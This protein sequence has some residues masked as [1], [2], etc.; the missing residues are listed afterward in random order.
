MDYMDYESTLPHIS[1]TFFQ[2][3]KFYSRDQVE[4]AIHTIP[5]DLPDPAGYDPQA[6]KPKPVHHNGSKMT[7]S[8][9]ARMNKVSSARTLLLGDTRKAQAISDFV[10]TVFMKD[11]SP[12]MDTT[13]ENCLYE[14]WL[15]QISN[16]DFIY[17]NDTG[18]P[19]TA[20]DLRLQLLYNMSVDYKLYTSKVYMHLEKPYKQWCLEQLDEETPSDLVAISALRHMFQVNVHSFLYLILYLIPGCTAGGCT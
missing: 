18:E 20:S 7:P 12:V 17:S 4:N 11:L 13:K 15:S 16:S 5:D 2:D 3:F 10:K 9:V 19:Y 8:E 6:P 1:K 14:A